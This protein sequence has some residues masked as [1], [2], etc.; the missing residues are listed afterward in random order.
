MDPR[1]ANVGVQFF[2]FRYKVGTPNLKFNPNINLT[3]E[4]LPFWLKDT[5]SYL[6]IAIKNAKRYL[7]SYKIM[8]SLKPINL[9]GKTF[10]RLSSSYTQRVGYRTLYLRS[11]QYCYVHP[12]S[13]IAHVFTFTD[14]SKDYSRHVQSME[15]IL[16]TI[17]FDKSY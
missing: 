3:T 17:K 9:N 13:K 6:N 14:L 5:K 8:E 2:I 15:N 7:K 4:K 10:Y 16:K 12:K 11:L 1:L